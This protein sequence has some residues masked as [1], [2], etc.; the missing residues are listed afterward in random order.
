MSLNKNVFM[1]A[2][3][4]RNLINQYQRNLINQYQMRL[5]RVPEHQ[6]IKGNEKSDEYAVIGSSLD[7]TKACNDV[8]TPKCLGL[9]NIRLN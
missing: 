5:I 2:Y 9:C 4:H 8:Q 7:E 1:F 6:D 3:N